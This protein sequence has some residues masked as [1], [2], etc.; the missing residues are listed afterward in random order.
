VGQD[1]NSHES[2]SE[3]RGMKGSGMFKN[4]RLR[5]KIAAGYA[6]ILALAMVLGSLAVWSMKNVGRL[7]VKL[8]AEFIPQ[9]GVANN[10]ERFSLDTMYNLR[11]FAL[12]LDKQYLEAGRNSLQEVKKYLNDAKQLAAKYPDLVHLKEVLEPCEAK[13]NEFEQ[14]VNDTVDKND[15]IDNFRKE[16]DLAAGNFM[17]SAMDFDTSQHKLLTNEIQS[18]AASEKLLERQSRML[19]IGDVIVYGNWIRTGSFKFQ[20]L[21]DTKFIDKALQNF[22]ELEKKLDVMKS[23]CTVEQD[24][25]DISKLITLEGEYKR[26]VEGLLANWH[27]LQDISKKREMAGDQLLQIAV[28]MAQVGMEHVNEVAATTS[29]SLSSASMVMSTGQGIVLILGICL[30]I[31]V[32]RSITKPVNRVVQGLAESADRVAAASGQ[33]SSSS[34]ELAEGASGQAASIEETSSSLEEI[35][36]MTR[37][38]A[39]NAKQAN[40]LMTTNREMVARA[41]RAMERLTGSMSEISKASEDTSKIIKTIDEI[42]FQTNLLALNA[43]V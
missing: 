8:D 33:V 42:A 5:F 19:A 24:Q 14:L 11:G 9:V 43:A 10:V 28:G 30:A 7:S 4:A 21:R 41:S 32:I 25:K 36:S 35:S 23:K 20:A 2:W 38:N 18:A 34:Q 37:Q 27:A 12:S 26:A 31:L 1:G 3:F 16:M 29:S 6:T 17:E 40:H 22:K 13:V 15:S 39:S